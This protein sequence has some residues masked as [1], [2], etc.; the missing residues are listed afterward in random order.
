VKTRDKQLKTLGRWVTAQRS[1]Y[2]KGDI[3]EGNKI[4]LDSIGFQ[5]A[6]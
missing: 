5:W 4:K 1:D 2:K 6:M 3:A